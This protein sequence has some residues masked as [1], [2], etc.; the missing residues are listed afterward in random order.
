MKGF[1]Y[2]QTEFNMLKNTIHLTDYV[3]TAA[4]QGFSFLSITD[5]NMYGSY[6]FYKECIKKAIKPI[7]GIEISYSDE[8]MQKSTILVYA[9]NNEGYQNLLKISTLISQNEP[10]NLSFLMPY[11]EN[12]A[13]ISVL[14]TSALERYFISNAMNEFDHLL[15]SLNQFSHF[16]IGYSYKNRLDR[17][18]NNQR[19]KEY[20]ERKRV[21]SLPIHQCCY[22]TNDDIMVYETLRKI[23][24]ENI[25]VE[26]HEDYCF[27]INPFE[28][29]ELDYFVS[30]INLDLYNKKISLPKYPNTKGATSKDYL[31]ALCFKGLQKRLRGE[32]NSTY[33]KRLNKELGIIHTMGYDDYFLIVW[34]FIL[35]AKKKNILVGPGRGSAAGSLVAYCLGIT[36]VDPM[37]YGLYFERF[38]NPERVSMP[39]IDTDFPDD[40]RDEIIQYVKS[41]YGQKHVCNITTFNTFLLKSSIRDLG[42]IMKMET[43]RLDEIVS[44]VENTG[45]YDALLDKFTQREDL[46]R[47]LYIVKKL[48]NLPRHISTHAAGVILSDLELDEIIPLQ[49]GDNGLFQSQF[50]ASDL[51]SIGLLK[52]DFLGIRNLT[53][54]EQMIHDIPNMS[55]AKLRDIPL[56]DKRCYELL[57]NAD[58]L[59]V[60]QLESMGIRNVLRKVKPNNFE[61]LVAVLALYRPGPME[62]IDEYVARR[63]G[64]PFKYLH[65]L[66]EPILR[67]TY[68]IIIYQE[69]IMKIVQKFAG[70]SLGEAD[71]LRRA[72]SKKKESELQALEKNFIAG[73]LKKGHSKEIAT[74]IYNYILKFANYG[75]NRSHSVAYGLLCYQMLFIKAHYFT[76]FIAN[77]LN[78]VAGATKTMLEYI[79]SAKQ[80]NVKVMAPNINIS[81]SQFKN[82]KNGLY[83]PFQVIQ[84]ISA[85]IA[86]QIVAE[87]QNGLFESFKDFKKR[88]FFLDSFILEALIF[89][90][91]LDVFGKSKKQLMDL[92]EYNDEVINK[93]LEGKIEDNSEYSFAHLRN[94]ELKYLGFN[95]Q[96]NLFHNV[97]MLQKKF[98]AQMLQTKISQGM[99]VA[100]VQFEKVKE[101]ITKKGEKMVIGLLRDENNFI[102]F[103]MFPSDYSKQTCEL[104]DDVLYCI[105]YTIDYDS[106]TSKPKAI[107][108]SYRIAE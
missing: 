89:A 25:V 94:K 31:G 23:G 54:L 1:L 106:K 17:S 83:L 79:S 91:A 42:K 22:L 97:D 28:C 16:Y 26:P 65:P 51:E 50:E 3:K 55:P 64:K 11:H 103:V 99:H 21:K 32:Q 49:A 7:V 37:K 19:M 27:D 76:I 57:K 77:T 108:R 43:N 80:H 98:N 35:Y 60:F 70:F 84:S 2:G 67:E 29:E 40:C 46:Y 81:T 24:G 95:I 20:C 62:N 87:R 45:D 6:K 78:N 38:L 5:K 10:E 92:K 33:E 82:T 73:A 69:Q 34:D 18:A 75:F 86:E 63:N 14:N 107:L 53:L 85:N 100:I 90:G 105:L 71:I 8:D 68:G 48:E 30:Q 39:D 44:M 96:Y 93:Y 47:F 15:E 36:E 56:D 9:L 13:I 58:T 102:D 104:G 41:V 74:Q 4:E 101:V 72:V 66:L 12:I 61:D 88:C 59:G 52:M